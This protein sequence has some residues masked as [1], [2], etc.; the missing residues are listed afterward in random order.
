MADH[1]R[2]GRRGQA[3]LVPQEGLGR[4]KDLLASFGHTAGDGRAWRLVE[5]CELV[6]RQA[7]D[8]VEAEDGSPV[9]VEPL[10]H[11]LEGVRE[12]VVGVLL[13]VT[14]LGIARDRDLVPEAFGGGPRS[15]K[16]IERGS[17]CGH[18]Q[19]SSEG[20]FPRVFC[21]FRRV[22]FARHH[23]AFAELLLH[24]VDHF[25][26]RPNPEDVVRN[27]GH[28]V[29][30]EG[31][32]RASI[33]LDHATRQIEIA[34]VN[35][36]ERFYGL[37]VDGEML[38]EALRRDGDLRPRGSARDDE[39][40]ERGL[41]DV[42]VRFLPENRGKLR[43]SHAGHYTRR[44]VSCPSETRLQAFVD[45]ELSEG[46]IAELSGHLDTCEDC[47]TLVAVV[48]PVPID[49]DSSR[50]ADKI[51]RYVL[52]RVLGSGGMGMVYEAVDPELHRVVALKVLRSDHEGEQKRLLGEA[53]AMALLSHP[54]VVGI[55]DVGHA[56]DRAFIVMALVDGVSLRHWLARETH[57]LDAI[58]DA[59]EQAAEGLRAAH[60][61]GLVHRDFKPEN[62]FVANDGRVLVGDFGLAVSL[63]AESN[64]A[65][66]SLAYMAPE[67]RSGE[68]VD[69]R[70]DQYAFCVALDEALRSSAGAP[71][72]LKK[73]LERGTRKTPSE[74][75][76]SM[77]ALL[78]ALRSDRRAFT[79]T[80]VPLVAALVAVGLAFGMWALARNE[81]HVAECRATEAELTAVWNPAVASKLEQ[82]FQRTKS[83]LADGTWK[84]TRAVLDDYA[85]AWTAAHRRTCEA[86]R[87]TPEGTQLYDVQKSCL[88]ERLEIVRAIAT[89]LEGVD[90]P[91]LEQVPAVLQLLP[92]VEACEDARA[93][94]LL[95]PP[96]SAEKVAAVEAARKK[97]AAASTTIVG[98]RYKD[99]LVLADDAWTSANGT[100]YLPVLAEAYLWVGTA[101]G[102][103]GHTQESER[104]LEQ[105]AS[106]GS[107]GRAPAIAI[108][109]WIKLMQFVGY[110]GK[111]YEDGARYAEYAKAALESMPGAFEL[112]AE[113][114]A[115]SRAMLLDRKRF[116][117]ALVVSRQEL[118]LVELRFGPSHRLSATALDG[119]AGVLV[120]QCK[121][122]TALEPQAK[123]CA[124][125]EKEY[126]ATH[127]QLALCLGNLASLHANLGE[128]EKALEI[129][130]RALA[131]F[132]ALP[133]HPNHVAMAHRN[134]VRS[135]LELGRLPEAQSELDAAAALSH[136]E[137]D[138]TSVIVLRGELRRRQGKLAEALVEHGLAVQ[139]TRSS[140][141]SRRIDPLSALAET[142]LV[143]GRP[144]EAAQSAKEAST[145]ARTVHGETSC[146]IAEPM[147]V[148]AEALLGTGHAAEA[149][150]LAER[151]LG[152]WKASESDPLAEARAAF[153]VA[154]A[155]PAGERERAK[156]LAEGALESAKRGDR[157]K[158]L[159]ARIEAWLAQAR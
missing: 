48:Q 155:L 105:A 64:E 31:L 97:I 72:W 110:E 33:A 129:K 49:M 62:V 114:L 99:G 128:H 101:H 38:D 108:R 146:R 126:G 81:P 89:S 14:E 67:Q 121:A 142:N 136:R 50:T 3:A 60:G 4:L 154:R 153:A 141:P 85:T 46:E 150:P 32:E 74:R 39:R 112:E 134:M 53:Q 91:M 35:R 68:K 116:D 10:E 157:D 21:N 88:G 43:V 93:I 119:H 95:A 92:R 156:G 70:A 132:A 86:P 44:V 118:A 113:R 19:P 149:L 90:G 94:A 7:L 45:G 24:F 123:A 87:K 37:C 103:L 82:A 52:R 143:A 79:R 54:N 71:R 137:S 59:F 151:A 76:P 69:A 98:G 80:R 122:R 77:D 145:F 51:G 30:L 133:G 9:G 138:E 139:R 20:A 8:V 65:A 159:V 100:G 109:A 29:L 47:R 147:R 15:A 115:W 158:P 42:E 63:D 117:E 16:V 22:A 111:R 40:E 148:E 125:L 57:S 25:A 12:E 144:S 83:P 2:N 140:E 106:S 102:R 96:P 127:P 131:M 41:V 124:I 73:L 61:A 78:K 17:G 56:G 107:A 75:F 55:Y 5:V 1:A 130:Q 18:T 84:K 13:H 104:A 135:L 27:A 11:A 6:H 28:E 66:G 34:R 58:L 36:S 26:A 120:G 152:A 23:E